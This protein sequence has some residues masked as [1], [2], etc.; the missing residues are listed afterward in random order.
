MTKSPQTSPSAPP[1]GD[2]P[3]DVAAPKPMTNED[4]VALFTA[5]WLAEQ[6][7]LASLP[8]RFSHGEGIDDPG[9][10]PVPPHQRR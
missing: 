5:A 8:A 4:L 6:D 9:L 3:D 7:K 1:V 10:D 2:D